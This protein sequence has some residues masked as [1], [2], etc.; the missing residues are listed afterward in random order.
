LKIEKEGKTPPRN[1]QAI[2]E[3]LITIQENNE[4]SLGQE[5]FLVDRRVVKEEDKYN[6]EGLY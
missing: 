5:V 4:I 1:L 6:G 2:I 3:K